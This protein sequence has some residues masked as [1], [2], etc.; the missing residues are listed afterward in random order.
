MSTSHDR[1]DPFDPHEPLDG[2]GR[3][4]DDAAPGGAAE[5][6]EPSPEQ[7]AGEERSER[8]D[9][10]PPA[11]NEGPADD[12]SFPEAGRTDGG[13]DSEGHAEAEA[14]AEAEADSG[15]ALDLEGMDE[16]ALRRLLQDSV[17]DIEPSAG[18][19]EHLQHAVPARRAR[20]RNVMVGAA[21]AVLACGVAVPTVLH[22]DF[23]PGA[24]KP[25]HNAGH[26]QDHVP[27]EQRGGVNQGDGTA[28]GDT[29]V[30]GHSGAGRGTGEA[31][32]PTTG[33]STGPNPSSSLGPVS[34]TCTRAQLG[35]SESRQEA[36]DAQGHVYGSFRVVNVSAD[37][38]TVEGGGIVMATAQGTAD[39]SM[40]QVVDHTSGDVATGLPDPVAVDDEVVLEPGAAYVVRFAWVPTAGSGCSPTTPPPG[41]GGDGAQGGARPMGSSGDVVDAGTSGGTTGG[42][43]EGGDGTPEE[44]GTG[45]SSGSGGSGTGG[46]GGSGS[47][48]S[49]DGG[50]DTGGSGSG[51][52]EGGS[53]GGGGEPVPPSAVLLSHT[54]EAG[55]PTV[56]P[57][58]LDGAC[59]G[60]VYRTGVLPAA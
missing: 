46:S 56:D 13:P 59:A 31:G 16:V 19:L 21:A 47:G 24:G 22:A 11:V 45:G 39:S 30:G 35:A 6:A 26:S 10:Q 38:C 55:E 23:V 50:S 36:P 18:T 29:T 32:A 57:V 8:P 27:A 60:T 40:I 34:P 41:E 53:T 58:Q 20:R 42:G 9:E 7:C 28:G 54:P 5:H 14:E 43:A 44:P 12:A 2:A 37:S 25:M 15:A 51:G 1:H 17:R 49:G 3:A 48:G 52:T 33:S 4:A